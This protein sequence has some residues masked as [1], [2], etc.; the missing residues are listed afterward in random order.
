MLCP[1][2]DIV[3][4]TRLFIKM[5]LFLLF[6]VAEPVEAHVHGFGGFRYYFLYDD[7]VGGGVVCLNQCWLLWMS[8]FGHGMLQLGGKFTVYVKRSQ[9][10]FC[11]K[12]HDLFN[13][14]C[15]VVDCAIIEEEGGVGGHE[16]M[17]P[18]LLLALGSPR[19]N[20]LLWGARIILLAC[21]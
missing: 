2:V 20:T 1:V 21:T 3:G 5:E 16:K 12:G 18:P 7:D 9:F 4:F 14:L 11:C 13:Y 6:L 10:G 8:H 15:Y 17:S 19:C